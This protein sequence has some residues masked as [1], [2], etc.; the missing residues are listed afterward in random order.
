MIDIS[1]ILDYDILPDAQ[2]LI[3]FGYE[4]FPTFHETY[5]EVIEKSND[6]MHFRFSGGFSPLI[7]DMKMYGIS[8]Q[9]VNMDND[10][11]PFDYFTK[12]Q[13][14]E[15]RFGKVGYVQFKTIDNLLVVEI[16]DN[17]TE[18]SPD[19]KVTDHINE[20]FITCSDVSFEFEKRHVPDR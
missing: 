14:R 6:Y 5:I 11:N 15:L 7:T 9:H 20:Y 12:F 3:P 4:T 18:Y 2:K 19:G 16:T 8:Q 17:Y 13:E 1:C 10:A